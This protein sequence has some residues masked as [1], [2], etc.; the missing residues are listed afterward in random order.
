MP[1]GKK[2]QDCPHMKTNK[3]EA[4]PRL[5]FPEFKG[6]EGWICTTLENI[7]ELNP[8][9]S[10][11]PSKFIY[12]DL[13][14]VQDSRLLN[15][16]KVAAAN[17]PSR[18]QRLL[19]Y[20]DVLFQTVRPYQK[21]NYFFLL[22]DNYDYVA[23]TGYAQLRAFE[24]ASYLNQYI[25]NER[26]VRRVL[27]HCAGG[28]YPAINSKNLANITVEIPTLPEQQKIAACLSS[29]DDSIDAEVQQLDTLKTHKAGLLQ[30]LFPI[31]KETV[32]RYRFAEFEGDGDWEESTLSE[33]FSILQGFA[34]SS[35]NSMDRGVRWLKISDV[36]IQRMNNKTPS[37]LPN[38][39]SKDFKKF[40]VVKGDYVIAM[41]RPILSGQLK[42]SLVDSEYDGALLNQRVGKIETQNDSSFVYFL[43][44]GSQLIANIESKIA[45]S[46]PP[47]LSMQ[48]ISD[49]KIFIPKIIEQREIADCLSSLDN[50]IEYQSNK[51]K[52]IKQ[53]KQGLMQ[54]L[55]PV[56]DD[57]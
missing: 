37:Y 33:V 19:K 3:T 29:L 44:Q 47:N 13:E 56:I 31:G 39:F 24:S 12:I 46:E 18:A 22:Q 23:S 53:H 28:N 30:N 55:F 7:A 40:I 54:Q 34:F 21:N 57:K 11:L 2:Y 8:S 49:I 26:F 35:K 45:G 6:S 15:R 32:P 4:I 43:L 17:S 51:V 41:T 10:G 48:Q 20:G 1:K 25:Y 36:G 42:I 9:N 14:S 5:R 50:L 38:F 27:E 52:I 16:K